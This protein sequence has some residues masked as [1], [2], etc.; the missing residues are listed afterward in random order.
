MKK[1]L[2]ATGCV[3]A[4]TLAG[5]Q[6]ATTSSSNSDAALVGVSAFRSGT[7]T[8]FA[9]D[10][11]VLGTAPIHDSDFAIA[12]PHGGKPVLVRCDSA[13]HELEGFVP[14]EHVRPIRIDSASHKVADSLRRA[15][16]HAEDLDESTLDSLREHF[17]GER[18]DSLEIRHGG[19][20]S[21]GGH[22][23]KG[24]SDDSLKLPPPPRD[25]LDRPS[26]PDSLKPPP[27]PRDSLK[28]VRPVHDTL[29]KPVHDSL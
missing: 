20:D 25:T 3:L 9:A 10:S 27:F 2:L 12:L 15:H 13:G 16:K 22:H 1:T 19:D 26:L 24:P 6:D 8:A 11:S 28:P 18:H 4:A 5:C 17:K 7:A 21:L 29:V 23:G 14:R